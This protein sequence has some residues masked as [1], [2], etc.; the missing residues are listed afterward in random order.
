VKKGNIFVPNAVEKPRTGSL[1]SRDQTLSFFTQ[2]KKKDN[3]YEIES[4]NTRALFCIY[5]QMR[6][7]KK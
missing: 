4:T 1:W 6:M 5:F 7:Q 2:A 3:Q